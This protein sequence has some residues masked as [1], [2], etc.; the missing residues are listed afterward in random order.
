MTRELAALIQEAAPHATLEVGA[1]LWKL[2]IYGVFRVEQDMFLQLAVTGPW[3]CTLTVRARAPIGNRET[4][5]RVL[6]VVR[7]WIL[8]RGDDDRAY[9][10]LPCV[11]E[12]AS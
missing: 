7:D 4:S 3:V 5:R 12:L 9:L 8:A 6:A 10:E 11:R 1:D 2:Y